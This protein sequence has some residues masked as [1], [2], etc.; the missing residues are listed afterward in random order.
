MNALIP[1]W[2][3]GAPFLGLVILGYSFKGPTATAAGA[4]RHPA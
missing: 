2:I 4:S 3:I 1:L